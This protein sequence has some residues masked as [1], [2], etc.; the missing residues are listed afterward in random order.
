MKNNRSMTC[1]KPIKYFFT[2]VALSVLVGCGTKKAATDSSV[3]SAYQE[4]GTRIEVKYEL[5]HY[6][7]DSSR[8]YVKVNT[9]HLLYARRGDAPSEAAVVVEITP[10]D[11]DIPAKSIRIL[12]DDKAKAPKML[13]ASTNLYIPSGKNTELNITLTD[14]NRSRSQKIKLI[15]D[16]TDLSN[17]QNFL[18][19]KDNKDVPL[20]TDR[21]K[22]YTNY[23]LHTNEAITDK[24][25]VRVYNRE[26]P[27][28][29]PPFVLY[30]PPSFDY[31]ADSV[32]TIPVNNARPIQIKTGRTGFYHFHEDDENKKG[33][34]IFVSDSGFPDVK[35]VE[36]LLSPLRYLMGGREYQNIIDAPDR[37]LELEN[38]WIGWAGSR[39]RA[40]K[41][42][43]TYYRRV[44]NANSYFSSH[45][46]GWKSDRGIIY[47]VYGK[48]NKVYRTEQV[49]TW[50]YGEESNPL[51]V[52]F[53][54]IKVINPFTDNDYRLN[55]EELY[56]PS[57]YRS[58]NAWRDGRIY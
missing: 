10:A 56:K 38:T 52:T 15:A 14:E 48:P 35:T 54:F 55:R 36:D 5:F 29:P 46:E 3:P 41:T 39:D 51:S 45:V 50:I 2:L 22:P 20:F 1:S 43:K 13:I 17:R 40:R 57:W 23:F 11:Q 33:L 28:P 32:A 30:E 44:E 9:E 21:V 18:I 53:H 42:I 25:L 34:T 6:K 19:T 37:K 26:F 58:V 8:L 12:D 16:K 31:T 7:P 49:E 24:I 47:I 27:M 4:D